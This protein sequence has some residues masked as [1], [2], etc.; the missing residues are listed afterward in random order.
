MR[1]YLNLGSNIG[2]RKEN[3]LRAI[4]C[5]MDHPLINKDSFITSNF[6]E[7][8]PWGYLSPNNYMNV[9]L[10]FDLKP[11]WNITDFFKCMI[12]I[13]NVVNGDR[14]HRDDKGNYT[15][16]VLDIDLIALDEIIFQTVNLVVPHPRMHLREFVLI[17]MLEINPLWTHPILKKN[18]PELLN[19]LKN[20]KN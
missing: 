7:S 4:A 20:S 3:I 11:D 16:R 10:A 1:A 15:D 6:I 19:D 13:Q 9:G 2:N 17:P 14:C 18:V 5:F 12:D 8:E